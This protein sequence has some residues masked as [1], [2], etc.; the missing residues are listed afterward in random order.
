MDK[1]SMG[2]IF[3]STYHQAKNA[4]SHQGAEAATYMRS[5]RGHV[6]Y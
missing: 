5:D 6:G 1:A 3:R 4:G 2:N